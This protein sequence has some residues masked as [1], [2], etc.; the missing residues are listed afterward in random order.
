MK[1]LLPWSISKLGLYEKCPAQ[2]KYR[3]IDYLPTPKHPA[4]QRGIDVHG[5][6]ENYL[7]RATKELHPEVEHYRELLDEA[8][9]N[10]V[11]T[12]VKLAVTKEWKMVDWKSSKAWGRGVIDA[13]APVEETGVKAFEWKTGKMYDDHPEQRRVYLLFMMALHPD[14]NGYEITTYYIDLDKAITTR[15]APRSLKEYREELRLRVWIM[16]NDNEYAPRPGHYCN[17]CPFSRFKGGPC[18]VG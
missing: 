14:A 13:I 16:A 15:A 2:A 8:K 6:V 11:R 9:R 5:S 12:E 18:R 17:W 7:R 10:R 4:A 1:T 3:H